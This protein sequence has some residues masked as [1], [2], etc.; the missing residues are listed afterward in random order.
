MNRTNFTI[1][2]RN[3]FQMHISFTFIQECRRNGGAGGEV[4]E[5]KAMETYKKQK[6]RYQ[7]CLFLFGNKVD[8]KNIAEIIKNPS[9]FCG[10]A[11]SCNRFVSIRY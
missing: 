10:C 2:I 6:N 4:I 1:S 7:L 11:N 3:A 5:L 8:I 9:K